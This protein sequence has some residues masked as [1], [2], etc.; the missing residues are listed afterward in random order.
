MPQVAFKMCFK[1]RAAEPP[2]SLQ[3]ECETVGF[4]KCSAC[5]ISHDKQTC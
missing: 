3:E 2:S 1:L 5:C 4:R